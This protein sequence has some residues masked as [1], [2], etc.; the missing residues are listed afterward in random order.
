MIREEAEKNINELIDKIDYYNTRYYQESASDIS[1]FEFDQLLKTLENLEDEFPEF[2]YDYSPTQRVGGTITKSFNSVVHKNAM[3]SL[4]NTYS[5]EELKDF[6][7]RVAKGLEGQEYEYF[8]ELK[9]DGVAISLWYENG[10]LQKAVTRGDGTRGD[11]IT[12]NAKTIRTIPLK[13]RNDH[14]MPNVFEVRGE[15]FMARKVFE[16]LNAE[17]ESKG[18]AMLANPRNTTSG[19]LKMQDSSIVAK[20]KLDCYLYYFQSDNPI[21]STHEEAMHLINKE[22]FN[23]SE[24]YKKC[25]TIHEVIEYIENWELKRFELPLDTDGI[26]IKVNNLD[27]QNQ[28]GFTAKS[29]RWAISYKYKTQS[30]T[31]QLK[32]ITFQ[33]GRTG[34]ITPVAELE[35]VLLAGTTVKR[36]SLYNANEIV[37][38]GLKIGDFVFVEKGGEIIPKVTGVDLEN[39]PHELKDFVYPDNCPEC[40][41]KLIR[42]EGEVVHY[43]PNEAGCPPQVLGRIEHFIQRKAMNIESLGPETIRG[44]LDYGKIQDVADLYSL[45][46][47]DLNGLEF[48]VYSD[49]KEGFS[50]RTLR[51]KS[52]QNIIDSIEKSKSQAFEQL[53]FGLGIRY[54]GATVSEKLVEHFG[55]I[56]NLVNASYEELMEVFEIGARIAE[57]LRVY[58]DD[59]KNN[60]LIERLIQIGLKTKVDETKENSDNNILEGKTFVISGVFEKVSRDDL[61]KLIKNY[62][63][64]V[65]S[66][67]SSKLDYLVAGNNMGPSKLEKAK[68]L[69]IQNISEE[70]FLNMIGKND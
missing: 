27:Q 47:E 42:K 37:R 43:C 45:K 12:A 63:G 69:K 5:A 56:R 49:K 58:F 35:P 67:I 6:D 13:L 38:L 7:A 23:V 11:D 40:Q 61:K 21:V 70:D 3:L 20:R 19:T 39:R 66:S 10:V 17:K 55:D 65:L 51:E 18:E 34:A 30:A 24:T 41:T 46:Y 8:C 16:A 9:F 57:S 48:K 1:D 44:L 64:K 28:L 26:V 33:V 25:K 15:V 32:K 22:G 60:K 29:P 52:A 31:T 68:K 50:V 53:L 14:Q 36:A 54:V 62:G 2:K 59:P 4:S